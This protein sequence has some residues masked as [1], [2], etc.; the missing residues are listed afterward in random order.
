[1]TQ[2]RTRAGLRAA[3]TL[4]AALFVATCVAVSLAFTGCQTHDEVSPK[5]EEKSPEPARPAPDPPLA[6]APITLPACDAMNPAAEAEQAA[7][8]ESFG[9]DRITAS[10]GETDRELFNEFASPSALAAAEAVSQDRSC[11]WV[12]YLDSVYLYQFTAELPQSAMAPLIADLRASDFSESSVGPATTF[13]YAYATGDMRGTIGVSHTFVGDVWITLIENSAHG[14]EQSAVDAILAANPFL[15]E[16]DAGS[17]VDREPTQPIAIGAAQIAPREDLNAPGIV[18]GWDVERAAQLAEHTYD[19][20]APLSWA[21]LPALQ[22][23]DGRPTVTMFFHYGE[24][25]GTDTQRGSQPAPAVTRLTRSSVSADYRW[26]LAG[27]AVERASGRA[28]AKFTWN[29]SSASVV[30]EGELPP[31]LAEH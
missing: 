28:V 6:H 14:Y 9:V 26:R 8:I 1:M 19:A 7:F 5:Q 13:A 12:V 2:S 4:R 24:F 25:A 21:L 29:E 31:A 17:C 10:Y 30:R 27:D 11:N 15:A 18:G 23:P 16:P 22:G 3:R 20:C